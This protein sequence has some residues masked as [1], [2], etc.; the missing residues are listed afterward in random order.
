LQIPKP[1]YTWTAHPITDMGISILTVFSG[2]NKPEDITEEDLKNFVQYAEKTYFT[3]A[4][5]GYLTVLFTSNFINPSFSQE[6]KQKY[7]SEILKSYEKEPDE[8]LP[9][10]VYCRRKSVQLVYRDLLPMLTGRGMINFFPGGNPG[11]PVCGYCITAIQSLAIGSP[12]CSGK[13]LIVHSEDHSFVIEFLEEWLPKLKSMIQLSEAAQADM[14]K[15]SRPRTRMIETIERMRRENE[16]RSSVTVYH[17]S[18]SGQ[19]PGINI[20]N[21]PD[22]VIN[23]VIKTRGAR[24]S[25]SWKQIKKMSWEKTK[26]DIDEISDEGRYSL[27]NYLYED[28]FSLFDTGVDTSR[29]T[30]LFVKRYFLDK[31][32][33]LEVRT[34]ELTELFLKEV[35]ALEKFRI[36]AIRNLGDKLADEIEGNNDKRLWSRIIRAEKPRD[37]RNILIT[38][39]IKNIKDSRQPVV[40]F[41][42]YL[43]I[44]EEGEELAKVDWK[45]AWDLVIIRVI[46]GLYE[47]KWFEKNKEMLDV[48]EN[49]EILSEVQ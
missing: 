41:D 19:G 43:E 29:K 48:K 34:W 27:T 6:K 47:K 44:F 38:Q 4:I 16:V 24:Y 17:I 31:A 37:V 26:K 2:K 20:Y 10:C 33:N 1:L 42:S 8:S 21:L 35:V 11:L 30:R 40:S 13:A 22:F 25:E 3:R 45:L 39:S 7:A 32:L 23:F 15:I 9:D 14:P 5:S 49:E 12:K 28:L 46:D 36:D 18:N